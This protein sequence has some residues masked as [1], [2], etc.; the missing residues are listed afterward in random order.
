M[1]YRF[2]SLERSVSRP[3]TSQPHK[4][5]NFITFVMP[6]AVFSTY[7][8]QILPMAK[9]AP[10]SVLTHFHSTNLHMLY[11]AIKINCLVWKINLVGPS[12]VSMRIV[13]LPP[14]SSPQVSRRRHFFSMCQETEQMNLN[15]SNLF[16]RSGILKQIA[17]RKIL[18]KITQNKQNSLLINW[19]TPLITMVRDMKSNCTGNQK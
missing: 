19:K 11:Q 3:W 16:N 10:S 14:I 2:Y 15:L 5:S 1:N 18:N 17:F 7:I 8:S 6:S 13:S 4:Y 9:S 12:P